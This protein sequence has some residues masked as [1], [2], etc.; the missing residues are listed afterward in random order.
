MGRGSWWERSLN[1]HFHL[2]RA[3]SPRDL[4]S[5]R[6]IE[7]SMRLQKDHDMQHSKRNSEIVIETI[8]S[9]DLQEKRRVAK[10]LAW[11]A[12]WDRRTAKLNRKAE[13]YR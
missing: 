8:R 13:R 5:R 10:D 6:R 7:G 3:K 12:K 1:S 2:M 11:K 9:V 4:E